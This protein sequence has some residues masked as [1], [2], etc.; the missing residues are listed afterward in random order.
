[1]NCYIIDDEQHNI[2]MLEFY[3]SEMPNVKLV[4]TNTNPVNALREIEHLGNVDLVLSDMDM[5]KLSGIDVK[6]RL[7]SHIA[8]I[9]V[10]AHFISDFEG[11]N[12]GEIDIVTK[13]V[14]PDKLKAAIEKAR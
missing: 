11:L 9:F 14:N 4:G 6:N 7:P 10:T 5:N 2:D 3:I 12:L 8:V 1:M 13:P